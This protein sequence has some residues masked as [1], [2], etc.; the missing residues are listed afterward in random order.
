MRNKTIITSLLLLFML[1]FSLSASAE[2]SKSI[3]ANMHMDDT[4]FMLDASSK[5]L[6]LDVKN[7]NSTMQMHGYLPGINFDSI[8]N[9]FTRY[10]WKQ[11][12]EEVDISGDYYVISICNG[13]KCRTYQSSEFPDNFHEFEKDLDL[14]VEKGVKTILVMVI[15]IIIGVA[16]FVII[17]VSILA[18]G[19]RGIVKYSVN[20][21]KNF[22]GEIDED[23]D[24]PFAPIRDDTDDP[25]A[26]VTKHKQLKHKP[27]SKNP[28]E[29]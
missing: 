27:Q 6:S 14:L 24:D 13:L 28:F 22:S 11:A 9:L 23:D 15:G 20:I 25:Y 29:E 1:V 3:T 21:R 4:V 10:E 16:L 5:S 8:Y 18:K 12:T 26:A 7:G 19:T 2:T 17:V